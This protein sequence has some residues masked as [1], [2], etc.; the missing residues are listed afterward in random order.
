MKLLNPDD[1]YSLD[2]NA[3]FYSTSQTKK[4]CN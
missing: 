1:A 2:C 3:I 4:M